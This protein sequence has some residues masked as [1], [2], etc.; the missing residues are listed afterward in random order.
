M[1]D[2]DLPSDEEKDAEPLAEDSATPFDP[3]SAERPRM[4]KISEAGLELISSF[5]GLHL[6]AYPD[7]VAIPTIGWGHTKNVQ[8]GQA[9]ARTSSQSTRAAPHGHQGR[10]HDEHLVESSQD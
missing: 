5:E 4:M 3:D 10:R 7:P 1:A 2:V 9:S 8:L 6:T